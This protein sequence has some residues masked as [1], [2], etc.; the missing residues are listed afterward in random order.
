MRERAA[1]FVFAIAG[2][3][4]G[5][6]CI[7]TKPVHYYTL[8]PAPPPASQGKLDGPVLLVGEITT[9]ESLQDGRIRYRTGSNEVGAYEYHRWTERPGSM[10]RDALLRALRNSG[11]YRRVLNSGSSTSGD[12]LVR[13]MLDEFDE[14]DRASIRTRIA[15]HVELVD[16]KANQTVWDRT[17]ERE[18]PVSGNTVVEVVRSMDRNL[19]QLV[20]ETAGE[21]DRFLAERR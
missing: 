16:R 12:Y 8:G 18:E 9:P 7:S 6:G 14:V 11:K 21:I 4:T 15:L 2:Y 20:T 10:V 19:Q 5:V 3:L 1:I 13:G 17:A